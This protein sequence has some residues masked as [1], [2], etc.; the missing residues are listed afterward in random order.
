MH[1]Q[2][3]GWSISGSSSRQCVYPVGLAPGL[4]PSV[5]GPWL[6]AALPAHRAR[7]TAQELEG[8]E[9]T[10]WQPASVHQ[11]DVIWE[12][13]E[14]GHTWSDSD[15]RLWHFC[16]LGAMCS[17]LWIGPQVDRQHFVSSMLVSD[18]D[19]PHKICCGV[20]VCLDNV[21]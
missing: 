7:S 20:W 12:L 18:M 17:S 14:S 19:C 2:T 3:G 11:A 16:V 13:G 10:Q 15:G 5:L 9:V 1:G 21:T 8:A 4:Q 6:A